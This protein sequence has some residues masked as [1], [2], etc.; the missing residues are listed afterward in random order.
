MCTQLR[1]RGTG[2]GS[3][4]LHEVFECGDEEG[5]EVAKHDEKRHGNGV[6]R[7]REDAGEGRGGGV[8]I[9]GR[10]HEQSGSRSTW[11]PAC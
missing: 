9:I 2:K 11:S 6:Q 1:H 3:I 7:E 5:N 10:R 8:R 4:H